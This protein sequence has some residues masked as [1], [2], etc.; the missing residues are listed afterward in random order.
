LVGVAV[1]VSEAPA[2]VGF[3]PVVNAIDT[4]G[5]S[6]GFTVIVMPL[7]VAVVGLAQVAFDV[8]TQVTTCP[9]VKAVVVNVAE[10]VPAFT[11]STFH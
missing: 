10:F 11:P 2:H 7:L 5:T 9:F 4:D 3:V 1:N 8:S 6:T